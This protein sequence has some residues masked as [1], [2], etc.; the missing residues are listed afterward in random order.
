MI[1]VVITVLV[2]G[3]AYWYFF[4]GTGNQA[5]LSTSGENNQAQ[6]QFQT[7]L[8]ELTPISFDTSIFSDPHFNALV[9]ITVP[10]TPEPTGRTDP[11]AGFGITGG[12]E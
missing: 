8:A 11:F 5:P 3:F 10:V 4:V 2:A 12:N 7:V 1:L 9:D 6:M